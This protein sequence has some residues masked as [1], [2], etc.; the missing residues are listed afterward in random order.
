MFFYYRKC[1]LK[2][3][4]FTDVS[5]RNQC[6]VEPLLSSHPWGMA[7]WWHFSTGWPLTQVPQIRGI[8]KTIN[9]AT[10]C[11]NWPLNVQNLACKILQYLT[12]ILGEK[13]G[14]KIT[15]KIILSFNW[16]VPLSVTIQYRWR[17]ILLM[18]WCCISYFIHMHSIELSYVS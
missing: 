16:V 10:L 6:T 15:W 8:I 14:L 17:K 2:W 5:L 18:I 12:L 3:F 13:H 7:E 9:N 1:I 11:H 4:I